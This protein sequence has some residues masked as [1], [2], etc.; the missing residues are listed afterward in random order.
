MRVT[1]NVSDLTVGQWDWLK[2]NLPATREFGENTVRM[3]VTLGDEEPLRMCTCRSNR[4]TDTVIE[5]QPGCVFG[6]V[7]NGPHS[8]PKTE[9]PVRH[10]ELAPREF[11]GLLAQLQIIGRTAEAILT[12]APMAPAQGLPCPDGIAGCEVLHE[13][14]EGPVCWHGTPVVSE[15]PSA[16]ESAPPVR[17]YR[18][19][20]QAYGPYTKPDD[21]A[22]L[23]DSISENPSQEGPE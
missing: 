21:L 12:P 17:T 22:D 6:H 10:I 18:D 19:G 20:C 15:T 13:A 14:N 9:I 11:V 23:M 2:N 1:I 5:V 4:E 7:L 3:C 8:L 16:F